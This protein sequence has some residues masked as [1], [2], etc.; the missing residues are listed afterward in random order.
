[1]KL[2]IDYEQRPETKAMPGFLFFLFVLALASATW[3]II[4]VDPREALALLLGG[5]L[6]F[7]C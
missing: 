7:C 2:G 1:M 3:M 6:G 4:G 5:A